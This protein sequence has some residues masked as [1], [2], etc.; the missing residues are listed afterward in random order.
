MITGD[1]GGEG[2]PQKSLQCN[3][4]RVGQARAV[5]RELAQHVLVR[6]SMRLVKGGID[7]GPTQLQIVA[8]NDVRQVVYERVELLCARRELR[9][10]ALERRDVAGSDYDSHQL[11]KAIKL[12][13]RSGQIHAL[14]DRGTQVNLV[15]LQ[16]SLLDHLAQPL[17]HIHPIQYRPHREALHGLSDQL[18][19][20]Q[21]RQ[22]LLE[23]RVGVNAAKLCVEVHDA[24]WR[25]LCERT[26]FSQARAGSLFQAL[27]LA[28]VA[29]YNHPHRLAVMRR[30][31]NRNLDWNDTPP[32]RQQGGF[33]D[34]L[35]ANAPAGI[36]RG[37]GYGALQVAQILRADDGS[38]TRPQ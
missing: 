3:G 30:Y 33:P 15:L 37:S 13:H 11:A 14:A 28:D 2:L 10:H 18:R 7:I 34:V 6:R 35:L 21:I 25:V 23:S 27:T 19:L 4:S 22:D 16:G 38:R 36:C 1:L 31:P 8:D 5:A 12:G 32:A 26:K 24:I 17:D 9:L 20:R 29:R